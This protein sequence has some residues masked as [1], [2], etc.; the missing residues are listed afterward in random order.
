V[1][2]VRRSTIGSLESEVRDLINYTVKGYEVFPLRDWLRICAAMDSI[3]DTAKILDRTEL[4]RLRGSYAA[5]Y[6]RLYGLF[7]AVHAQQ[8]SIA[9]LWT[10]IIGQWQKPAKTSAWHQLRVWRN[11]LVAHSAKNAGAIGR[12]TME[13]QAPLVTRLDGSRNR[14]EMIRLPLVSLLDR[15]VV[16]ASDSLAELA[17]AL[18]HHSAR[19]KED[20]RTN[21]THKCYDNS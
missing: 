5:K 15:Y 20:P 6:L 3:G 13:R 19:S 8:D 21:P 9:F 11:V 4:R 10:S 1:V 7:Q 14:P 2:K 18:R 16:E 12:I 17:E